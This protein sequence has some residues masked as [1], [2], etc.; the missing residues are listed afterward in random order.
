MNVFSP[1]G[2]FSDTP[3][4]RDGMSLVVPLGEAAL[5]LAAAWFL[6]LLLRKLLNRVCARYELPPE[7]AIGSP[8]A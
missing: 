2:H 5:I 4:L 8:P 3:W 1:T 7:L 6:R